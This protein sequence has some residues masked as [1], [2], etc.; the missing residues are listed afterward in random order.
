MEKRTRKILIV[1]DEQPMRRVVELSLR[2]WG[3]EVLPAVNGRQALEL[4]PAFAPDLIISDITMPV[5][6]GYDFCTAVRRELEARYRK[7]PFI[8][9]TA[10]TDA[11]SVAAGFRHGADDYLTKPF[12]VDELRER[13]FALVDRLELEE[14]IGP[15]PG[16]SGSLAAVA[17][18]DVLNVLEIGRKTGTL[19]IRTGAKY[20]GDVHLQDGFIVGA[21]T[22]LCR[23]RDALCQLLADGGE[24]FD[25][26]AAPQVP[27]TMEPVPVT[28]LL[29]E[30][31]RLL[32]ELAEYRRHIPPKETPLHLGADGT[33]AEK[34]GAVDPDI[35]RLVPLLVDRD[36]TYAELL[37]L[38]PLGRM[39]TELAVAKMIAGGLVS[40]GR[41]VA[42]PLPEKPMPPRRYSSFF[43]TGCGMAD[44]AF[45]ERLAGSL[46]FPGTRRTSD[47]G[48]ATYHYY[49]LPD[50]SCI[51]FC[52]VREERR[53]HP[54]VRTLIG[55]AEVV[56]YVYRQAAA[57]HAADLAELLA[58]APDKER[59]VFIDNG[60]AP[61]GIH[62]VAEKHRCRYYYF[63]DG[64][65]IGAILS[66][67]F[68]HSHREA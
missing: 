39:Q 63:H 57:D 38:S 61:F 46:D 16:F 42:P 25:F 1:D 36:V 30:G 19:T 35:H 58:A 68:V 13:V 10:N 33:G 2:Q 15:K 6:N 54:L 53:H 64:N 27:A 44:D 21:Q 51:R 52:V 5:M 29:M 28:H 14:R 8:F 67:L 26:F 45:A 23:D 40:C 4:L 31:M 62:R 34:E 11:G 47:L 56:L 3:F 55:N 17:F 49:D 41:S 9:L 37:D 50:R 59:I 7:I 22:D 20:R 12:N 24:T 66:D 60:C 32:D 18:P 65:D 48:L 43:L